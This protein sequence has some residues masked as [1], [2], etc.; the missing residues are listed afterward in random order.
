[1]D[2]HGGQELWR[3]GNLPWWRLSRPDC[4]TSGDELTFALL[5]AIY[6]N[7]ENVENFGLIAV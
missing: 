5:E 6:M 3:S 7:I 1:M 2:V 4:W